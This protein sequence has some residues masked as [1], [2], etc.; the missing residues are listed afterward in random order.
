M[1]LPSRYK[2]LPIG[3]QAGGFGEVIPLGDRLLRRVVLLKIMQDLANSEQL[4]N[5][6]RGLCKARSRHVVEVYD[7][8]TNDKGEITGVIIERLRGRGFSSFHEEAASNPYGYLKTLFQLACALRDLHAVGIIHR[9][10]KIDNFKESAAGIIKLFDFG[11]SS[12]DDGYKTKQSRGTL[13]YA[14]PELYVAQAKVTPEMDIYALGVCAWAL[15]HAQFPAP[16]LE[17]PPQTSGRT[18]SISSVMPSVVDHPAG[19][20]WEVINVLDRCLDPEPKNRPTAREV[21]SVLARH[22]NRNRHR[23]LFVQGPQKVFELSAA[24]T[25]V[26]LK[27]KELGRMKVVYDGLQFIIT[28]VEGSISINNVPAEPGH[29]LSEACVLGFGEASLGSAR[30]W[31]SFFAS[32][33]EVV[34]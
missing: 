15:A 27:I 7:V 33:P 16:L 9:D 23:G 28:E 18:P 31:V 4:H 29:L 13:V 2:A 34:L 11:I 3:A 10:L 20:H 5:E 12:Q 30:Q 17:K 8:I 6:I 24:Q 25:S 21:S 22:L 19:L 1:K 32:H 26:S 14:A